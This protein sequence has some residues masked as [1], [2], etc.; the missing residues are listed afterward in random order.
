MA[1][2]IRFG[3]GRA[4]TV[5]LPAAVVTVDKLGVALGV[6]TLAED[7]KVKRDQ[8]RQSQETTE[9]LA[10]LQA[11]LDA[12]ALTSDGSGT[13]G[14][15]GPTGPQGPK[16][17]KGDAGSAGAAG[18]KGDTGL[19][20]PQGPAGTAGA[21]GPKGDTGSTGP[22]GATGPAGAPSTVAGPQGPKGDTGNTGPSGPTGPASTV[23][24][25]KGDPG[26][27]GI[28][29]D[30]GAQGPAGAPLSASAAIGYAT[31]AG[32]VVTQATS[33]ITGVTLN[34]ASG[35]ITLFSK[36]T[37]ASLVES[38]VVTNSMVAA[39]DTINVSIKATGIFLAFVTDVQA[40]S[41]RVSIFTPGATTAQAPIVNFAI[42]KAVTS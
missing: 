32:G 19:T 3:D 17:D 16:G 29:G 15:A 36:T 27:Q 1:V 20:G 31:G 18:V 13:V 33:R 26:I 21:Q 28:K 6:A 10:E 25:P 30:T 37:T 9:A 7:G 11:T 34:K 4:V 8:S 42:I 23:A 38:F 14:P 5:P 35:S 41:F 12:L 24:G 22:Q 40:G 39:T 2:T